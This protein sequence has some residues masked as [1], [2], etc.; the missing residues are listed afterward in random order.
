MSEALTPLPVLRRSAMQT[1]SSCLYRFRQIYELGVP[2][3]ND[4]SLR[5][6]AFHSCAHRY[7]VR[8]VEKQLSSDAEEAKLAFVEGI[9][10]ALTPAHLVPEVHGIYIKWAE[11]FGLDL[12]WFLAAEE[13]Q[14]SQNQTFTP[15]LVYG[16]PDGL[17]IVDFKTYFQAMT[18]VQLRNDYQARFYMFLAQRIFPNFP[19]YTFVHSYVRFGTSVSVE[20][21]P[22][23]LDGFADEIAAIAA[24][25]QEARDRDE[26]P[27]TA[28][29]ECGFCQLRCPLLAD[30]P[31]LAPV[32][33]TLP[34]QAQAVAAW[35]LADDIKRKSAM[36]ALKTYAAANGPI[37]VGGMVFDNR[38]VEQRSYPI[39]RVLQ[40]L[41]DRNILGAFDGEAG[42]TISHSALSKLMKS[43]PQLE[44]DLLPYQSSRTS[45]RFSAKKPGIGDDE[46]GE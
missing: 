5:G 29:V 42:L 45:Y 15:D 34:Q 33:F 19:K 43:F 17:I 22:S 12:E 13:R 1:A 38:P 37:T 20:F 9:A 16:R 44:Q 24:T 21:S 11:N 23:E 14:I 41:R 26:W 7:I 25:I 39:D 46:D 6:I 10:A 36:K 3:N 28:G 27:A 2:D 31:V 30:S 8:L 18:E 32:R 40:V 35:V 4:Y